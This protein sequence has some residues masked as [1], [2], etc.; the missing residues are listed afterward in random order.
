MPL[1]V[2]LLQMQTGYKIYWGA[3]MAGGIYLTL[4]TFV[5]ALLF[6]KYLLKGMRTGY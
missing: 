4:P 2:G 5:I 1:T 6:Q 3:L